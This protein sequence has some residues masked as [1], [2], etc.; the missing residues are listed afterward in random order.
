MQHA[1]MRSI[2]AIGA[3][4]R[5]IRDIGD[6]SNAIAA[7]VTEQGAAT[8]EIARSVETAARRT[9]ET[10]TEMARVSEATAQTRDSASAVKT[11]ADDLGKVAVR[12]RGQVDQFFGKLKAA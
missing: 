11:V 6:I 5:T 9:T 3:I 1:T 8:S 12:I 10:A 7:A 4:E 2:E